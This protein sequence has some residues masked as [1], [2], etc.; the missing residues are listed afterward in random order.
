MVPRPFPAE[1]H[2]LR[3]PLEARRVAGHR[4]SHCAAPRQPRSPA[5]ASRALQPRPD[6]ALLTDW[7]LRSPAPPRV[8]PNRACVLGRAAPPNRFP[9][10]RFRPG[11]CAAR[12][13]PAGRPGSLETRRRRTAPRRARKG[14]ISTNS[15]AGIVSA[16]GTEPEC[17]ANNTLSCGDGQL[18]LSERSRNIILREMVMGPSSTEY[19]RGGMS[20]SFRLA[21]SQLFHPCP[22]YPTSPALYANAMSLLQDQVL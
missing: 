19:T 5:G 1:P 7:R 18:F 17:T 20:A 3:R 9:G 2:D 8:R 10:G 4:D 21:S 15:A 14:I 22:Q 11:A 12:G 13:S 16:P 6:P